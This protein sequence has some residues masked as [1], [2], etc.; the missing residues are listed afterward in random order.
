VTSLQDMGVLGSHGAETMVEVIRVY[1]ELDHAGELGLRISAHIPLPQWQRLGQA[2]VMANFNSGRLQIGAVKSFS[3]GSLGST[4][5]WFFDPYSDAPH[6]CGL[7][8]D[9]LLDEENMYRNLRDADRAGL[10][11]VIHAIGD[12]ANSVVLGMC[13]ELVRENG[14]RDR[15][16]RIEHAQHL[17]PQDIARFNP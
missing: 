5:A 8:S 17:R 9:E 16:I 11:L 2:G 13:A 7:P 6:T 3:D 14:S 1:Q 10:Q 12:R 4:T 15:R